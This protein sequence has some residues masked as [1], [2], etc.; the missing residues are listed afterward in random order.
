MKGLTECKIYVF[1]TFYC[2]NV[3]E[4]QGTLTWP[5]SLFQINVIQNLQHILVC[6]AVSCKFHSSF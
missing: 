3:K 2:Q 6:F 4:T 5:M 1:V